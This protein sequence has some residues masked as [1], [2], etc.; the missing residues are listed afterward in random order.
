MQ[1][2]ASRVGF[3]PIGRKR[4]GFDVDWARQIEQAAWTTVGST[5][6]EVFRPQTR[7]V[8]DDTLRQ[9]LEELRAAACETLLVLQPTMGDGRLAPVLAQTWPG[10]VVFWAT[11]ERPDGSKVSSCSLVGTHAFASIYRQQGRPF[12]LAY[13]PPGDD[14]TTRQIER[15][16]RLCS[17]AARLRRAKV[18]LVGA[19]APGFS[20]MHVEPARLMRQL[21]VVLHHLGIAEFIDS[22]RSQPAEAVARELARLESLN[23][24]REEAITGEDLAADCRYYLAL[25]AL[26]ADEHLDAVALRCWPELPNLLRQWPYLALAR[27]AE[28][29]RVVALEGDVDGAISCLLGHLLGAGPAYISD[30]IEHDARAITLWHPGHA[31]PSLCQPPSLRLGRHF[32]NNLP[33]VLNAELLPHVP[34]T[35][36][37]LW[38]CDGRYRITARQATTEPTARPLLGASCRALVDGGDVDGWFEALCHEGMP[39]HVTV[40]AGHHADDLRRLARLVRIDWI[41]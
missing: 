16:V 21:G 2:T 40:V 19:P 1:T 29:G 27:L 15:A 20:N 8:D 6:W 26:L 10:P 3:L 36:Y 41:D 9:A 23:L 24:P 7:A 4:P 35:I 33:L 18:G 31:P 17:V 14:E 37:R 28:S 32:N 25:A 5:P 34:I 11:P 12:E 39:H 13:G 30:W 38:S 22:V